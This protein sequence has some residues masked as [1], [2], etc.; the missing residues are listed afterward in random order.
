LFIS[1]KVPMSFAFEKRGLY[2]DEFTGFKVQG[3]RS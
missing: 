1:K 3:D 2:W